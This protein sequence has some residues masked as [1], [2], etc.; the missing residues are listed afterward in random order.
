M[1][2]RIYPRQRWNASI[3]IPGDK[4]L[5]HRS[6][7]L[8]SLCTGTSRIDH[9][10]TGEDCLSTMSCLEQMGVAFDRVSTDSYLI[11]GKGF[12]GFSEPVDIL[13][14][15]NSGTTIRLMAGI[16]SGLPFF[17]C[18][19]GDSSLK[20]RPMKRVIEPLKQM[21]AGI[22]ARG[23][24]QYA[25]LAFKG[26]S[27]RGITYS[28]PV[29]SAQVKS[30][31]IL[32]ALQAEG[33][34]RITEPMKTR[35]HTENMI[36]AMGGEICLSG[37]EIILTGKQILKPI[38]IMVPGDFSSAAYFLAAS[39][40]LKDGWIKLKSIGVNA[41][42]TGF[43]EI[44][45]SMGVRIILEEKHDEIKGEPVADLIVESSELVSTTVDG[46]MI[47]R[48]IDELPL[49]AV[50]ATQ[51]EGITTVR[52][53]RE[54]RVKETDRIAAIVTEL[55]KMGA[56]IEEN[57]D[58]FE[59]KG[60]T[61]LKGAPVNSHGDH[62]IAMSLAVAALFAD[63]YTLIEDSDCVDISFPQFFSLLNSG[64]YE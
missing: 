4:S 45:E 36:R 50:L 12:E 29:A 7:L 11:K 41:T 26:S 38:N 59:V 62:R 33:E 34:T 14:A 8:G 13:D 2:E 20:K 31:L 54:L 1:D 6:L 37:D 3:D 64:S 19:T 56:T 5:S 27:L 9:L 16:L 23:G 63:G 60:P 58:G 47:P 49:L 46:A 35:D 40:A 61:P 44:L 43:L 32:A 53:A 28:M 18:I 51:A 10:L 15:G 57:D 25:P 30:A 22:W 42:R 21:G 52:D 17:S 55:R 24:D 39:A 48:C